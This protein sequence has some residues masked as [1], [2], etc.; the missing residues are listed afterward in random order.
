MKA[1]RAGAE[2]KTIQTRDG[3]SIAYDEYYGRK[4]KET[5]DGI[6][7]LL[8]KHYGFTDEELDFIISF[9]VKYRLGQDEPE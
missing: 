7:R 1:L 2:R 8:G 6:D 5:I 9:D 4:A 3:H